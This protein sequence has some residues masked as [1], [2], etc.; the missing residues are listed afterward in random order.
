MTDIKALE[1]WRTPSPEEVAQARKAEALAQE[2]AMLGLRFAM[3]VE[4]YRE[5]DPARV[6]PAM[7]FA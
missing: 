7:G 1:A 3:L 6:A 4:R 5:A 2:R